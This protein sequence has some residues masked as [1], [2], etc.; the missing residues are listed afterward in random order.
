MRWR[1]GGREEKREGKLTQ[2]TP[3]LEHRE[4]IK[5]NRPHTEGTQTLRRGKA[6]TSTERKAHGKTDKNGFGSLK[7][8]SWGVPGP[9][10][11]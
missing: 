8:A 9:G 5:R 2:S 4:L 11:E 6:Y 1:K 3:E 10:L 7:T